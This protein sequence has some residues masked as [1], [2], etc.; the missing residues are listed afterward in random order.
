MSC[1]CGVWFPT[2]TNDCNFTFLCKWL[3]GLFLRGSKIPNCSTIFE[4][5]LHAS[6]DE[7]L[8]MQA[9]GFINSH[10]PK[11]WNGADLEMNTYTHMFR[12]LEQ[13]MRSSKV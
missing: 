10:V 4:I 8:P 1:L 6:L 7:V 9:M 2:G 12:I 11:F 5:V 3:S 13:T